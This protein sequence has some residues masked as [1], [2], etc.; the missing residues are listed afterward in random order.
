VLQHLQHLLRLHELLLVLRGVQLWL[1]LLLLHV[2][3]HIAWVMICAAA[4]QRWRQAVR[5]AR[6]GLL[7][8]EQSPFCGVAGQHNN[9]QGVQ[10]SCRV[11]L[12][13][14]TCPLQARGGLLQLHVHV[15]FVTQVT[16]FLDSDVALLLCSAGQAQADT[17]Q[18]A[19]LEGKQSGRTCTQR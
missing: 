2:P 6:A 9:L 8:H 5:K 15:Q 4:Q 13:L 17:C 14:A 12:Q 19:P 1:L 18:H 11:C 3:S 7:S 16:A 10:G